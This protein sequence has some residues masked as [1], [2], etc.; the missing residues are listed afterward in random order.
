MNKYEIINS[1]FTKY[2]ENR[3]KTLETDYN[4]HSSTVKEALCLIESMKKTGEIITDELNLLEKSFSSSVSKSFYSNKSAKDNRGKTPI[5]ASDRVNINTLTPG[6]NTNRDKSVGKVLNRDD[7]AKKSLNR[8]RTN[9]NLKDNSKVPNSTAYNA[10]TPTN[11]NVGKTPEKS[12]K[13]VKSSVNVLN[14]EKTE[15]RTLSK[16]PKSNKDSIKKI[17]TKITSPEKKSINN[18]PI[19]KN[20]IKA[21]DNNSIKRNSLKPAEK[22]SIKNNGEIIPKDST[23]YL[24]TNPNTNNLNVVS[25]SARLLDTLDSQINVSKIIQ[26]DHNVSDDDLLIHDKFDDNIILHNINNSLMNCTNHS[27]NN[28]IG[29][30]DKKRNEGIKMEYEEIIEDRWTLFSE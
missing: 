6:F 12:L 29:N 9:T 18:V 10:M 16:T 13:N 2:L 24:N 23:T 11:R 20:S 27:Q 4:V 22:K 19:N 21:S 25:T 26:L 8:N 1:V 15:T 7:S 5:R 17:F 3:I 28:E 14:K 30:S